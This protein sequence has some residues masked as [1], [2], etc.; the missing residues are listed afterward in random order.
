LSAV[1]TYDTFLFIKAMIAAKG[2]IPTI[3]PTPTKATLITLSTLITF[4]T[5]ITLVTLITFPTLSASADWVVRL[6]WISDKTAGV[7]LRA[8]CCGRR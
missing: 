2:I 6:N 4:V 3:P 8:V 5:F 7:A 1:E